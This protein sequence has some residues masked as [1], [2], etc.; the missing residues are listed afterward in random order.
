MVDFGVDADVYWSLVVP[1]RLFDAA[2][3]LP[4]SK[5]YDAVIV[6]E[7]Q[8]FRDTYWEAVQMLL[9]DPS[10]G[11]LYI[12]YDDSQRLYSHDK[13][14]LPEPAG[15]LNRNLRS[16]HEIGEKVVEYYSSPEK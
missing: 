8:D 7:G 6:D 11:T 10:A 2:S 1:E 16:T 15:R 13:F 14:P 9:K 4:A 12:F 3:T 5:R